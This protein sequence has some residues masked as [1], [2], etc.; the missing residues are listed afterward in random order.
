MTDEQPA[1]HA[2]AGQTEGKAQRRHIIR[3]AVPLA[4]AAA[5]VGC[6]SQPMGAD[7][8]VHVEPTALT[9]SMRASVRNGLSEY[10]NIGTST[11]GPLRAG[12]KGRHDATFVC[13]TVDG[14]PFMGIIYPGSK[15]FY[16]VAMGQKNSSDGRMAVAYCSGAGIPL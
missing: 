8:I 16:V 3:P 13:G 15:R 5:L 7:K 2:R 9:S 10:V 12:T 11:F 1:A 4:M 6:V 14:Q